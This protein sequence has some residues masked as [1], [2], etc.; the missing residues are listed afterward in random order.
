MRN[1][2]LGQGEY[3]LRWWGRDGEP[4]A[5]ACPID[6][7]ERNGVYYARFNRDEDRQA[8][9]DTIGQHEWLVMRD[10]SDGPLTLFR[11]IAVCEF[12][13][14]G[15]TYT[16]EWDFDFGY[17]DESARFMVEEG[18]Y[19]CDCNR[20]AHIAA[21]YP[22]FTEMNC[23]DEIKLRNLTIEHRAD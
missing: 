22:E 3:L 2:L 12:E 14:N 8:F 17:P 21:K 4:V 23:G 15:Q 16:I 19:S 5:N 11:T 9:L 6:Y 18:N 1:A 13:Y 7:G 20:S 10:P